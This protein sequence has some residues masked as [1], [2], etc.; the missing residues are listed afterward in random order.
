MHFVFEEFN[1]DE[2]YGSNFIKC[3]DRNMCG[4]LRFGPSPIVNSIFFLRTRP[5]PHLLFSKNISLGLEPIA[6]KPYI[7]SVGLPNSPNEWAG[8]DPKGI[9]ANK[10]F[11]GR[12]S[13]F[14]YIP[15]QYVNDLKSRRAYLLLDQSHE[16][17][18]TPWLWSWFHNNCD[19]YNISPSQ[20]IYVTGNLDC[21]D[22]YTEWTN[23]HGID[24]KI[25]T[26]PYAHFEGM[27]YEDSSQRKNRIISKLSELPAFEDHIKYKEQQ[28]ENIKIYNALQKRPRAHRAWIFNSLLKN[29]LLNDGINSMNSIEFKNTHF[30]NRL[31]DAV[32]YE[33][34]SSMLPIMPLDN[35][36]NSTVSDFTS[37]NSGNYLQHFNETIM[38][39]S[40]LTVISEASFGDS[41][42]TCFISEKTF[43]PIA[44]SHPFIVA[45]NKHSLARLREMGYK[46]FSPLIDESYDNMSTWDRLNAI[47]NEILKIKRMPMKDRLAW[48]KQFESIFKYNL[49][50]FHKNNRIDI[51]PAI[52]RIY[53]YVS[54]SD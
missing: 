23:L 48:F 25:L 52:I 32:D 12:E 33:A 31:I 54:K 21:T 51:N 7:I 19:F 22:Q 16:G 36:M 8:S 15:E 37:N 29:D 10:N 26:V 50:I 9:G 46:T 47:I 27:V 28:L 14:E 18:Q 20:I 30:E 1:D 24:N 42:Q 45:G 2:G 38:L 39:D 17:Y 35:P 40:W 5:G 43:K 34:F 4:T 6:D 53:N 11:P 3:T 13:L 41:E 44:C 49:D